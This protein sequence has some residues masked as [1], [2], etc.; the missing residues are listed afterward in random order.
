MGCTKRTPGPC[1]ARGLDVIFGDDLDIWFGDDPDVIFG[2]ISGDCQPPQVV[3]ECAAEP[4]CNEDIPPPVFEYPM[5]PSLGS[6]EMLVNGVDADDQLQVLIKQK[7]KTDGTTPLYGITDIVWQQ[8]VDAPDNV[9]I[10][11]GGGALI[12]DVY[13]TTFI[14][15]LRGDEAS[16]WNSTV[17]QAATELNIPLVDGDIV[18]VDDDNTTTIIDG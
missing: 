2:I 12:D 15:R 10:I 18:I 5:L 3:V 16:V 1:E 9:L 7:Y 11:A 4:V 13:Y 17:F 14:R 6:V 8:D